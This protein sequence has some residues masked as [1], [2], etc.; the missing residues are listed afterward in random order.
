VSALLERA[1]ELVSI[2]SVSHSEAELADHLEG[3]LS[4]LGWLEVTRVGD[5]LVAR[6]RLGRA[7]RVLLG[8]HLDTV[9]PSSDSG[10]RTAGDVLYGVGAADMKGGLA[11]MC[12]LARESERASVDLT[13]AFYACEEVDRADNGLLA[14]WAADPGLLSC[15]AAVLGEPTSCRVEAGCQGTL[16]LAVTLR[17][18]RA[19]SARPWAGLNAVH[20]AGPLIERVASYQ[21]RR[22]VIDGCEYREALQVVKVSGGVANNVVPDQVTLRINHR[23]APDR[24]VDEAVSHLRRDVLG[25]LLDERLGD[26]VVVEDAG[27]AAPP[28][29]GDPVV[30]RLVELSGQPARAKLGW[31]DVAFFAQR[32]VPAANFG[33]GDPEVA[34]SPEEKVTAQ[35]L[36]AA[37]RVLAGLTG[38]GAR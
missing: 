4:G 32:G 5:N 1:A 33:P 18:R 28:C 9:P 2:P 26:E 35:E 25:G 11:V 17:G 8:G 14:L 15:D 30:S 31:T 3:L 7:R 12:E 20:R 21:G 38:A 16:R 27:P 37:Y 13:F 24:G 29:L 10:A 6:T 23:F 22:P 19:H 36:E 34:H